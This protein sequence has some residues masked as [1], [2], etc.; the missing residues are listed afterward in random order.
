[1]ARRSAELLWNTNIAGQFWC[2]PYGP[3]AILH[4]KT[5]REEKNSGLTVFAALANMGRILIIA[6]KNQ[7]S[8]TR[9]AS[10]NWR[11]QG[12]QFSCE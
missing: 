7:F 8:L 12:K 5:R 9:L 2:N 6:S 10:M 1:M 4:Q 3:I 11:F